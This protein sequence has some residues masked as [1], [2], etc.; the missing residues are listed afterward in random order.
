MLQIPD[1][2]YVNKG[3]ITIESDSKVRKNKLG[4]IGFGGQQTYTKVDIDLQF[5]L[6]SSEANKETFKSKIETSFSKDFSKGTVT[7]LKKTYS[8]IFLAKFFIP[9]Q[10]FVF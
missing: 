8:A 1:A 9:S 2:I 6:G 7:K 3:K 5:R 10:S 4:K